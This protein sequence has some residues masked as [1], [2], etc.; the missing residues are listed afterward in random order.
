MYTRAGL[1]LALVMLAIGLLAVAGWADDKKAD[2]KADPKD[3]PQFE[4]PKIGPEAK[5][6]HAIAAAHRLVDFGRANKVPEA[7]IVAARV[8]GTTDTQKPDAK[9][10]VPKKEVP[11]YNAAKAAEDLIDEALKMDTVTEAVKQLA[12]KT[13]KDLGARIKGAPGGPKVIPGTMLGRDDYDVF[14]ITF[15]GGEPAEIMVRVEPSIADVDLRVIDGQTGRVVAQDRRPN[16]DCF[17]RFYP[18]STK[19][20]IVELRN[21]RRNINVRYNL[22]TN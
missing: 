20:Y 13:R 12:E 3:A 15:R 6:L 4:A 10:E 11:E 16:D 2:P 14:R 8:I 5:A 9:D 1:A 18:D 7:L 17:V 21:Y 19:Q 22:Y